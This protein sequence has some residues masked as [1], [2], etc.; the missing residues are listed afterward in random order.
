MSLP[1]DTSS[2]SDATQCHDDERC[3][4]QYQI[5][6]DKL[7]IH[8]AQQSFVSL[9][10]QPVERCICLGETCTNPCSANPCRRPKVTWI[11]E[12][13]ELRIN[14]GEQYIMRNDLKFLLNF[15]LFPRTATHFLLRFLCFY[16][17][18][19]YATVFLFCHS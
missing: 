6:Q 5:T 8:A 19:T 11:R 7:T 4:M 9:L 10:A 16:F 2:C 17:I 15:L 14:R 1:I 18:V 13:V 12:K 3:E